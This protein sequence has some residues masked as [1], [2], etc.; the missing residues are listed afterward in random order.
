MTGSVVGSPHY[1][2][3][4]Q[5][6]GEELDGRSDIFSLGVVLY[7]LLSRTRPFEGETITTLVYQILHGAAA[8]RGAAADP[9]ASRAVL[10][11]CWRRTATSASPRPA[12]SPTSSR[13]RARADRRA[14]S[15]PAADLPLMEATRVLPRTGSD[16]SG[17]PEVIPEADRG[18][19]FRLRCRRRPAG[20]PG[21][22]AAPAHGR[23]RRRR[24]GPSA[25]SGADDDEHGRRP[26]GTRSDGGARHRGG[27]LLAGDGR[28]GGRLVRLSPEDTN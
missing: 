20:P 11:G 26:A 24:A 21:R 19:C 3:P 10:Q 23:R 16:P 25:S 22:A 8:D 7:E 4:E 2:S 15:A 27:A 13:L 14:L 9:G 1:L 28:G 18:R 12:R 5:I 6:R 17:Q